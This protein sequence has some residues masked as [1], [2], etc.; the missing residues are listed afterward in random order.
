MNTLSKRTPLPT[1]SS[2]LRTINSNVGT[3]LIGD[4]T[5][6]AKRNS[7]DQQTNFKTQ[8]I[9]SASTQIR[10]DEPQESQVRIFYILFQ[11]SSSF[12]IYSLLL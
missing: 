10:H 7:R 5:S 1:Q 8:P 12:F 6:L 4:N 11:I 2:P 3:N 9:N